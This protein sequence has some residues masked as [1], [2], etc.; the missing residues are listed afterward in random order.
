MIGWP[1]SGFSD[2]GYRIILSSVFVQ[3]I[4]AERRINEVH[5]FPC[6]KIE[7]WATHH[8]W[9]DLG[10]PPA[11]HLWADLGHPPGPPARTWATR[12]CCCIT[13][14]RVYLSPYERISLHIPST[15]S[16]SLRSFENSECRERGS[17]HR[18]VSIR[19]R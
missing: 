1:R 7:T 15:A 16:P 11:H 13:E 18:E 19:I 8:L 4:K 12:R 5:H 6:L 10:H 2:L 9:A 14:M 3:T 17:A